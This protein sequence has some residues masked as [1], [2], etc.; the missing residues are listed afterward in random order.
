M[1]ALLL[2]C[3]ATFD[4]ECFLTT[5]LKNQNYI[6][7]VKKNYTVHNAETFSFKITIIVAVSQA[8]TLHTGQQEQNSVSDKK[9]KK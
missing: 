9:L 8:V 3:K 4:T 7:Y 2:V 1:H 5:W 6:Y